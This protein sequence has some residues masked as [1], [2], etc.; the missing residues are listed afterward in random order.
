MKPCYYKRF[1]YIVP[2]LKCHF[3]H[4]QIRPGEDLYYITITWGSGFNA[5]K[6]C[7]D[8]YQIDWSQHEILGE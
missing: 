3:C 8:E 4:R 6:K 5:C 2:T 7:S 1:M